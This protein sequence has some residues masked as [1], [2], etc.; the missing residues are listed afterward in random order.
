MR[1]LVAAGIATAM[2]AVG[3]V[4]E[5]PVEIRPAVSAAAVHALV[6][7]DNGELRIVDVAAGQVS[8]VVDTGAM[9]TGLTLSPDGR[10]AFVVNGW[11]GTVA[12]VDV[13]DAT[14]VKRIRVKA[15]LDSA[16]VRPDGKRLYITGTANGQGVVLGF[17]TASD[18]LAAVIQVG[19]SPTGIAISPDGSHLYVVNNQGASLTVIDTRIAT[20]TR[21]VPLDV[22]PQYVAV[23][24][25]GATT[26]V[27]HTSRLA[28]TNGSVSVI[29]N[30]TN[31]VVGHIPVGVGACE[32][33]VGGD[34]LYVTN[35]Q[36]GTVSVVDTTTRRPVQTLVLTAR[37]IAVSPRDHS[38]YLATGPAI[39]VLDGGTGQTTSTIDLANS[40]NPATVIA[41]AG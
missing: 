17:D 15:E 14:V 1:A 29:D 22:L 6:A 19:A 36:D 7:G 33:A 18:S 11:S 39:T 25:D 13:A 12:V 40:R 8:A 38:V 27:S 20:A 2:L 32:L 26:Y 24:P 37:G 21:T 41:V 5:Q 35:L 3:V 31:Q 28:D 16:V 34:R 23:S 9:V 30:R 4:A 10:T